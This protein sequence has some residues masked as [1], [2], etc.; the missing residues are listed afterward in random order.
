MI[1]FKKL[2]TLT[3]S[4]ADIPYV[5]EMHF[6]CITICFPAQLPGYMDFLNTRDCAILI[7]L[8]SSVPI[9]LSALNKTG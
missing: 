4:F 5:A 3:I 8:P 7:I 2:T 1:S 9:I 6:Y